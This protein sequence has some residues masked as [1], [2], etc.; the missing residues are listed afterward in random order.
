[1]TRTWCESTILSLLCLHI[2]DHLV[3]MH[4]IC[5]HI[6]NINWFTIGVHHRVSWFC[7]KP[8]WKR[9]G[10]PLIFILVKLGLISGAQ[11][12]GIYRFFCQLLFVIEI[13]KFIQFNKLAIF[14]DFSWLLRLIPWRYHKLALILVSSNQPLRLQIQ[15]N[16]INFHR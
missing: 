10:K 12:F 7:I 9:V 15:L 6:W 1:M 16:I 8:K 13:L 3:Q 2:F 14:I 4:R 5:V 11:V